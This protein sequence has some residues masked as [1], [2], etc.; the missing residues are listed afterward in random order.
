MQLYE[1]ITE[2]F[3]AN[4]IGVVAVYVFG[5]QA[6]GKGTP[7]SDVDIAVL[8]DRSDPDFIRSRIEEILLQLPRS[9]RKDVHP[10]AMNSAS[11]AL[12]KQIF[13]KGEC[14]LVTDPTKLAEFKMIAYARIAG[15]SYY[16]ERMQAGLVRRVLEN[17]PSG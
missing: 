2:Y 13:A 10:V 15:F 7:R 5:S 3:R 4:P 16:L 12:L 6:S 9:L 8:F 17:A 11:E 1:K 14:L